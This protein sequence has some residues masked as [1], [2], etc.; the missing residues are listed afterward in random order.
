MKDA[1]GRDESTIGGRKVYAIAADPWRLRPAGMGP[2][3]IEADGACF[4]V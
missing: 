3:M 4:P 2:G 1:P